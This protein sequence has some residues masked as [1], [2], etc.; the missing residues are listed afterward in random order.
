MRES[1][2]VFGSIYTAKQIAWSSPNLLLF[3]T[4]DLDGEISRGLRI[5]RESKIQLCA[6]KNTLGDQI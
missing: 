2:C 3:N 1:H 4:L 5:K 6:R